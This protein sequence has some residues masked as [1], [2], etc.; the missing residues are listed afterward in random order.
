MS[1]RCK[2]YAELFS[3]GKLRTTEVAHFLKVDRVSVSRW[4]SHGIDNCTE[5]NQKKIVK[6][7]SLVDTALRLKLLPLNKLEIVGK[8]SRLDSLRR[9]LLTAAKANISRR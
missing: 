9:I 2:H 7:V 8:S 1:S 5:E 4:K 6:L 3:H